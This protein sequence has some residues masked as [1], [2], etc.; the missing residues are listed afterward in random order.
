MKSLRRALNPLST[1]FT[2]W[3][4]AS[5]LRARLQGAPRH[6]GHTGRIQVQG[7]SQSSGVRVGPKKREG[8]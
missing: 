3:W 1:A 2:E 4:C 7:K 5:A 8:F 6:R